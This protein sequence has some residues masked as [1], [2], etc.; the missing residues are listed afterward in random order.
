MKG[1]GC[2]EGW[3]RLGVEEECNTNRRDFEALADE[4]RSNIS[5]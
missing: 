4:K 5:M 3:G 2:M 1:L